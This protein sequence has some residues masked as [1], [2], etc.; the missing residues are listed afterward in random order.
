MSGAG[1]YEARRIGSQ[2]QVWKRAALHWAAPVEF[3]C[4]A[5][6]PRGN[7]AASLQWHAVAHCE[8]LAKADADAA[9]WAETVRLNRLQIAR[10]YIARRNARP[11]NLSL[12][13]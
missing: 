12:S 1:L 11:Q 2:W 4:L 13:L 7:R 10:A 9:Q 8:R 3:F 5:R 6:E